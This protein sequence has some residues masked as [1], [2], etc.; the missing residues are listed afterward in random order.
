MVLD[1]NEKAGC[2]PLW[3]SAPWTYK[4]RVLGRRCFLCLPIFNQN[5]LLCRAG[6]TFDTPYLPCCA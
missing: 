2:R 4:G 5:C 3:A 1:R 6:I